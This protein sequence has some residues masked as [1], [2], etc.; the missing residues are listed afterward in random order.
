MPTQSLVRA[1]ALAARARATE[2][3]R[4]CARKGCF[5]RFTA[6]GHRYVKDARPFSYFECHG[7]GVHFLITQELPGDLYLHEKSVTADYAE[8]ERRYV[9]WDDDVAA[10]LWRRAP[11]GRLLDL[12]S[13]YGDMLIAAR[14]AGYEAQGL[15]VSVPFADEAA[16]RSGCPVVAGDVRDAGWADGTFRVI[17]CHFVLEYVRDLTDTFRTLARLLEPGG[18]LRVFGYTWDSLPARLKGGGWWNYSPTRLFLFSERTMEYLASISGLELERVVHG[19]EQSV[20]H[21]IEERPRTGGSMDRARDAVD[22]ARFHLSRVRLGPVSLTSA[23]A[24]YFTKEAHA[25]L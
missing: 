25:R 13:G 16:R 6:S 15:D 3:C 8:G 10:E 12:G 24:F 18:V 14:R 11:G 17:N 4:L 19:G 7:C 5:E 21:F 23:R 1:S 20:R 9:H 2:V 22:R